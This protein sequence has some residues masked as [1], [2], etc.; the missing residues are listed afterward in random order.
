MIEAKPSEIVMNRNLLLLALGL[1]LLPAAWAAHPAAAPAP[2]YRSGELLV[3]YRDGGQSAAATALKSAYGLQTA[4]AMLDGRLE[5]LRL[6]SP[7]DVPAAVALLTS[8]PSVEYAEPNY[9]RF[10]R[11]ATP[12]DALFSQQWGLQNTGQANFV[13]GGPAGVPGADMN[14]LNAWDLNGDGLPDHTGNGNVIVAVLDDA[15]ETTHEDLAPNIVQGASFTY[16]SSTGT[17]IVGSDPNPDSSGTQTHGTAVAGCVAA[18]GNN[19]LGVSGTAW[20]EKIMPLKFGFDVGTE[21]AALDYARTHGVKIVNGSFGGPSYS[22]SEFDAISRLNIAGI[23]F[24]V[25]AGNENANNDSSGAEYPANYQLPNVIAVAATNRQ[26]NIA[27]FSSYGPVSI[28]V[29]APGLQIVTTAVGNG[30]TSYNNVSGVDNSVSG[31]SFSAPYVAG[32]AALILDYIPTA[33]VGEVKARLIEGADAGIPDSTLP[34]GQP[35]RRTAGG[36][37]NAAN[38]LTVAA[39]PAIVIAPVQTGSYTTDQTV[40]IFSPVTVEDGGN[41][42][43]DPGETANIRVTLANLW[44]DAVGVTATLSASGGGVTVNNAGVPTVFGNLASG[45]KASGT[46]SVSVPANVSGHQYVDFT[47]NIS[48]TSTAGSSYSASR[49]FTLEIGRLQDG[50]PVTQAIQTDLYDEFHTWHYDTGV[51]P[52]GTN[53]L[54]F[55]TTAANDVDII[56]SYAAPAQYEVTLNALPSDTGAF[57]F[58]S[59]PDAQVG[60]TGPDLVKGTSGGVETVTIPNPQAGTYFVTVV[61]YDQAQNAAYTLTATLA[62]TPPP[63]PGPAPAP[64]G[65]SGGGG[66]PAPVLL[67]AFLGALMLRRTRSRRLG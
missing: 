23:V 37:V 62:N 21:V 33:G 36:R 34:G 63:A 18:A 42:A 13:N 30:Y 67:A 5:L 48:A 51:L 10:P 17:V 57:F 54:T 6:P 12:N 56:V 45:A 9:L 16:N 28:P 35:I 49:H 27:S 53:S 59:V 65:G 19:S 43:L 38:A 41:G 14:L 64:G 40:P 44:S 1:A 32:I 66:A 58:T 55:K 8:D 11:G 2:L 61:N 22:S 39:R 25:A 24:V 4:K 15:V 3:K 50:V 29:A 47:V 46:F 7:M 52:A 26:D 20:N 31:T 60:K